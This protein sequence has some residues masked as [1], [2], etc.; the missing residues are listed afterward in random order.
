MQW[1]TS[2]RAKLILTI[3]PVVA[4]VTTAALLLAERKFTAAYR[5]LFEEQF[6]QQIATLTLARTR[7]F[8]ALSKVLLQMSEQPEVLA[9]VSKHDFKQLAQHLRPQLDQLAS[10]RMQSEMPKLGPKR[11]G[12]KGGGSRSAGARGE[13]AKGRFSYPPGQAPFVAFIDEKG[14][15]IATSQQRIPGALGLLGAGLSQDANGEVR[16]KGDKLPW[17]EDRRLE[18]VLQ[19]QEVGY[20]KLEFT[21]RENR[22]TEQVREVF[23]TPLREEKDGRFLGAFLFGLPLVSQLERMLYEQSR[24]S[25]LGEIMSGIW[26]ED[27]LVST[28]IPKEQRAEVAAQVAEAMADS[29]RARR[30][31]QVSIGGVRHEIFFRVLNPGSPFPIAA[32][33]NLYP[34]SAL[35]AEIRGLRGAVAALVALALLVAL[36]AVLW[37]SRNLSGP[38]TELSRAAR[39]IEQGNFSVRVPVTRRDELGAL[40]FSFNQMAAGLSLQ[41]KYRSVLNAV[42]DRTVAQQLIEQTGRLGGELR[43]VTMLFCD[44][45]GFTALTEHMPPAEVIELL[46]DHMTALTEVAY[47]HEGIVDKFV[48][49]LIMVLFGAPVSGGSDAAR[50]VQCAQ[51]MLEV[52][53]AHNES[54]KHPIEVGIGIATGDVVAGCMGSDQRLSY[55]VLGHSVNLASRLCGIAGRGEIIM[56]DATYEQARSLV[57]AEPLE[58]VQLKGMQVKVQPWRVSV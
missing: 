12:A 56:D 6:E 32:Q 19:E 33:V 35:D 40:A 24:R 44:I 7:R 1:F 27:G 29:R 57:A 13:D 10:E 25:E 4:V 3:F 23:I 55:T 52:R 17:L 36:L 16:R 41:E 26:V 49:D 45:R 51:A 28:T 58:P 11:D 9:A 21:D 34:L 38:V 15:F 20:L 48:G 8:E 46:N 43:N 31:M 30:E 37:I 14:K 42:A 2:F 39:E 22:E 18:D 53:R 50:A 54:A 5:Q 47:A